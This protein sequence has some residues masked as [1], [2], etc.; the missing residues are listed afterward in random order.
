MFS[1]KELAYLRTQKLLRIATVTP[2]GQPDVDAVSFEFDEHSFYIGGF[3]LQT[4]RKY[5]N[6]AAGQTKVSLIIDDQETPAPRGIKLHGIAKIVQRT[7]RLG[8]TD[9]IA[10]RPTVS[11][12]WGI[13]GPPVFKNETFIAPKTIWALVDED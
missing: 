9:Y 7:G 4:S 1:E 6:V 5:K 8:L 13:E 2:D 11:W 10:V 3:T 12:H